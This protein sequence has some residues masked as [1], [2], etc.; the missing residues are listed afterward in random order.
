MADRGTRNTSI[1]FG[2]YE[3][4]VAMKK[5]ATSRDLK[6]E[7][8]NAH[9]AKA[10]AGGGGG[11]GTR[12]KPDPERGISRAVRL[13][14]AHVVRL[15]QERLEDIEKKSKDRY[16]TMQVIETIDY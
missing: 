15:P 14:E 11:G 12:P 4:T 10:T 8:V 2:D 3:I 16:D 1:A 6:T 9:G 5:A 7:L 13:S